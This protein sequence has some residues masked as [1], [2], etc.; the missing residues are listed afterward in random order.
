MAWEEIQTEFETKLVRLSELEKQNDQLTQF[1]KSQKVASLNQ[2]GANIQNKV[3]KCDLLEQRQKEL[4][5]KIDEK[6]SYIDKLSKSESS[7][8]AEIVTANAYK[9]AFEKQVGEL[10]SQ[11]EIRKEKLEKLQGN[12][13]ELEDNLKEQENKVKQFE[14][15]KEQL[16]KQLEDEKREKQQLKIQLEN[17]KKKI[18]ELKKKSEELEKELG[19][20]KNEK[21]DF[22][23]AYLKVYNTPLL[24][25]IFKEEGESQELLDFVSKLDPNKLYTRLEIWEL[26]DEHEDEEWDKIFLYTASHTIEEF[27][28]NADELFPYLEKHIE[29]YNGK[30]SDSDLKKIYEAVK[31]EIAREENEK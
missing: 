17:E 22:Y 12:N 7:L 8:K 13:K 26:Y 24:P 20:E 27:I 3:K 23:S 10:E 9:D 15:E 25:I 5:E 18:E 31:G 16:K 11:A 1:L 14:Q 2:L 6:K 4:I 21:D 28:N 30:Y 19:K 29:N